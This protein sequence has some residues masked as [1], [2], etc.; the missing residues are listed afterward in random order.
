[1]HDEDFA[2]A[3]LQDLEEADMPVVVLVMELDP[4][5]MTRRLIG[6]ELHTVQHQD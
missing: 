4:R 2:F 1:M 3:L 5:T 6:C